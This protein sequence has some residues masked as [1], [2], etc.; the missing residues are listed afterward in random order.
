MQDA[1][2]RSGTR[3]RLLAAGRQLALAQGLRRVTVRGVCQDCGVNLGSFVYHF[4]NRDQFLGEL[5]ETAYA[6]L[7]EQIRHEFSQDTP[8]AERL[9]RMVI[10]LCGFLAERSEFI[11]QLLIDA[12]AGEAAALDFLR[13]VGRRHPQLILRCIREAQRAGALAPA[14]PRHVL[15]FLMSSVGLPVVLAGLRHDKPALPDLFLEMLAR[16][17]ARR[18]D[19][20]QR[21]DWALKGLRPE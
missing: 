8:P 1:A 21:L 14:A 9:R 19:I 10:Q 18:H 4:G 3:Q 11:A 6:P 5:I 20:E 13:K 2:S 16:H 12:Y 15:M 17:G 7:F